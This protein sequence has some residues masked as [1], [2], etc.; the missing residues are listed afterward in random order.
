MKRISFLGILALLLAQAACSTQRY[1]TDR[2]SHEYNNRPNTYLSA[3]QVGGQ[4]DASLAPVLA[5]IGVAAL[6]LNPGYYEKSSIGG[7]C[8]VRNSE[9]D[10]LGA[11]CNNIVVILLDHETHQEVS[12]K[13]CSADGQFSFAVKKGRK[14][15]I[16]VASERY[17]LSASDQGPFSQGQELLLTL[18][19]GNA[20]Q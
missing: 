2:G 4:A 7:R 15:V 20:G 8:I 9:T 10:P 3:S 14:Y 11:P 12:R 19:P 13:P 5:L 17:N 18:R 16:G 6:G 1:E